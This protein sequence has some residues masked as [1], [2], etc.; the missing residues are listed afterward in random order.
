MIEWLRWIVVI[1]L[2]VGGYFQGKN[3]GRTEEQLAHATASVQQLSGVIEDQKQ[4]IAS[5]KDRAE[6]ERA[7]L[8]AMQA[9]L[10][11]IER[12]TSGFGTA[13]R[14]ALNDSN[15]G[16]CLLPEP[17]RSV[18]ADAYREAAAAVD[19]ANRARGEGQ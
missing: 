15:L 11:A 5:G 3:D 4:E 6:Q 19:A 8:V 9:S 16:T 12:R 10:Q 13:I 14:S 17:V 7:D 1:G 18:R 2:I